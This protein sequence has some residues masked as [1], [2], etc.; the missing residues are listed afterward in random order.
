MRRAPKGSPVFKA[1][2]AEMM[3]LSAQVKDLAAKLEAIEVEWKKAY[4]TI[5]NPPFPDVPGGD[6]R[7]RQRVP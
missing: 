2:V 1:K 3:E 6:E 4:L 7:R 5:P